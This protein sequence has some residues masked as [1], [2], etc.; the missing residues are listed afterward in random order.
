MLIATQTFNTTTGNGAVRGSTRWMAP[1][2][3]DMDDPQLHSKQSDVWALGMTFFVGV[4]IPD[5]SSHLSTKRRLTFLIQELLSGNVPYSQHKHDIQ[6]MLAIL[7]CDLPCVRLPT[8]HQAGADLPLWSI[9][10]LCWEKDYNMRPNSPSIRQAV[11]EH[12]LDLY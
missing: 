2:L 8:S 12:F 5:H 6:V 4:L 9:C 10:Q 1:E 11:E 7:R 3:L